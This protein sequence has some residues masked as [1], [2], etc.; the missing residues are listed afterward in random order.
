[1]IVFM[2]IKQRILAWVIMASTFMV[3]APSMFAAS[4]VSWADEEFD[5][6]VIETPVSA[7]GRF[8]FVKRESRR[9]LRERVLAD[10]KPFRPF[11]AER[12]E[13]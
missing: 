3:Y 9:A 4:P 7:R 11:L 10:Q 8:I 13:I 5:S 6:W 2:K 12:S 1:M